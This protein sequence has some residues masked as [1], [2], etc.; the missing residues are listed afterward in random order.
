MTIPQ[1]VET[2]GYRS[3]VDKNNKKW[4]IVDS[5]VEKEIALKIANHFLR[6]SYKELK[7]IPV[8]A[9]D[10]EDIVYFNKFIAFFKRAKQYWGI[11]RNLTQN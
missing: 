5:Y 10:S 11:C 4:I 2:Y 3:C 1:L 8:Y 6:E 9:N 7:I